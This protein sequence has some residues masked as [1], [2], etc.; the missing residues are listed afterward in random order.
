[1][2][3]PT[4]VAIDGAGN[5]FIADF[6][7]NAIRVVKGIA[8]P[9]K[10]GIGPGKVTIATVSFTKPNLLIKGTGFG[11]FG[12]KV[13]INGQDVSSFITSQTNTSISLKG[14]KKKLKLRSG[15]NQIT[16]TAGGVTSNT[17]V[18]NLFAIDGD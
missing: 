8:R 18:L 11:S 17:F 5:L 2:A 16:V 14:N 3:D 10:V 7:N 12:A 1:L 4:G 6:G 15:P 13:I 9:G